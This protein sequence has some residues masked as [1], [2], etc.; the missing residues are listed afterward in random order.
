MKQ[1][2]VKIGLDKDFKSK[3][4]V[5]GLV[6]STRDY[7]KFTTYPGNRK[8]D[9]VAQL[10]KSYIDN[11]AIDVPIKCTIDPRYENKL[12]II[13]GNNSF[14]VRREL[15][16]PIPYVVLLDANETT[17][18]ALNQVQKNW[19]KKD[20]VHYYATQGIP[21]YVTFESVMTEYPDFSVQSIEYILALSLTNTSGVEDINAIGYKR[22]ERG[23]F[24]IPDILESRNILE[25][26]M[27]I[28]RIERNDNPVYKHAVFISALL[29]LRRDPQFNFSELFT[30]IKKYPSKFFRQVTMKGYG[31]LIEDLLNYNRR[32]SPVRFNIKWEK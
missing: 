22:L 8:P 28:K 20:F 30:A 15:E 5:I 13:D 16:L 12:V 2:I 32:K 3:D 1:N 9:H 17:M 21:A 23:N 18:G 24:I 10:I 7:S 6:F 27:E 26:L 31:E 14:N 4:E 25:S 29:R 19:T 11:G